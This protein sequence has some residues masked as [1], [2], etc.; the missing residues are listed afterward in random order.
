MNNFKLEIRLSFKL[1]WLNYFLLSS[2][3]D[4]LKELRTR[5]VFEVEFIS[6]I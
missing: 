1:D 2:F 4:F 5:G 3:F 6:Y